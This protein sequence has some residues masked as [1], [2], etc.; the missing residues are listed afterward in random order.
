MKKRAYIVHLQRLEMPS[1]T[2]YV[3][4]VYGVLRT[5]VEQ[6]PALREA[7]TFGPAVWRMQSVPEMLARFEAPDLVGFSVYVWNFENSLRLARA[8]KERWP[9][10]R[11]VFGG[12][13]VSNDPSAFFE[14]HP[15][16]DACV[17]G[18]GERPFRDLLAEL[19]TDT[20][21]L[22]RVRG[23]SYSADGR[24]IFTPPADR[25]TSLDAPGP[26]QSGCFDDFME[27]IRALSTEI[28]IQVLASLETTRGCPFSCTFCD[29][30]MSTMS[31]VRQHPVERVRA[32]LD[33]I[34]AHGI[35]TVI[36]N[37][38]NFGIFERDVDLMR[39]LADLKRRTGFPQAFYPLGFAKNNKDRAF[40]INQIIRDEGFD[41]SGYNVNFSLQSMSA[42]TLA[43]IG[44]QNIKLREARERYAQEGYQ[45]SPDLILPLPGETLASFKEGY[46]ELAAWPE[47]QRIR[48]YPCTILPN[49]P[50]A[51]PAYREQ[52]GLVTRVSPLDP[53][54]GLR[55]D[56]DIVEER[57]ETVVATSTMSELDVAEAKLFVAVV[58]ALELSGVLAPLRAWVHEVASVSPGTFYDALMRWQLAHE[59]VMAAAIAGVFA[60]VVEGSSYTDQIA[61]SGVSATWDGTRMQRHKV[62]VYDA[63]TRAERFVNELRAFISGT[64]AID[65]E[66]GLESVLTQMAESWVLPGDDR[67]GWLRLALATDE[68]DCHLLKAA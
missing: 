17:H 67:D 53:Q 55:V 22:S 31:K 60:G 46:A 47:V 59:G 20:P 52:W 19:L 63:L 54:H 50:M 10:C 56:G 41:P 5:Y 35:S 2:V 48:I 29:W 6:S 66:R 18:E 28:P 40:R 23:I 25:L 65:G 38:S 49:A 43:A 13:H 33:W 39:H 27:E 14:A 11:V 58:D 9:S 7:W 1:P 12:P 15:F 30:G 57:I 61:W 21:D 44:R 68:V 24:Q 3:P 26:Y 4:Y 62:V 36:L 64:F 37:D 16:V 42:D 8:V 51:K 32:E 34:A 45:L